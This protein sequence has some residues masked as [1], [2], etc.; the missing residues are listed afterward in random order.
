MLWFFEKMLRQS[1]NCL[2][3][4]HSLHPYAAAYVNYQLLRCTAKNVLT[5]EGVDHKRCWSQKQEALIIEGVD[6]EGVDLRW[7]LIIKGLILDGVPKKLSPK[8][9][10]INIFKR[11]N[12]AVYVRQFY[13]PLWSL[14]HDNTESQNG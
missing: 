6:S 7:V 10:N 1:F 8:K 12:A 4:S 2:S 9:I 11:S 5:S 13:D 3:Q 14:Q